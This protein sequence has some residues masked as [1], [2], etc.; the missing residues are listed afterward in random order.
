M[1]ANATILWPIYEEQA[2]GPGDYAPLRVP[3]FA[4]FV[5]GEGTTI[6]PQVLFYE[7]SAQKQKNIFVRGGM[8]D[9]ED[10]ALQQLLETTT[11]MLKKEAHQSITRE[12]I[13]WIWTPAGKGGYYSRTGIKSVC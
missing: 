3:N 12:T 6:Y 13:D 2:R 4:L 1:I 7:D 11:V 8:T 9:T 10:K 5:L